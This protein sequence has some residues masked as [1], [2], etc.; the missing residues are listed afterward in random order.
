MRLHAQIATSDPVCRPGEP[1]S[2]AFITSMEG[3]W[4]LTVVL[5]SSKQ[6]LVGNYRAHAINGP[7]C[8][9]RVR[10]RLRELALRL[11]RDNASFL[12]IAA[13]LQDAAR[14]LDS[15]T[16]SAALAAKMSLSARQIRIATSMLGCN[17]GTVLTVGH[18]AEAC[19]ISESHFRRAFRGCTGLAP[20]EWRREKQLQQSRQELMQSDAP[21]SIIA[22]NAGFKVQSHFS[23]VF[24]QSS[25]VT[26]S[27]W[28][29]LFRNVDTPYD[30]VSVGPADEPPA[31]STLR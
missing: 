16:A 21:L 13:H 31:K 24:S 2:A 3:G 6:R 10:Q 25:G 28:R 5:S 18:V 17:F 29:R 9:I 27:E 7:S 23:R 1:G 30:N 12:N 11:S 22:R 4:L 19:G 8:V 26:P 15:T 20:T 14:S